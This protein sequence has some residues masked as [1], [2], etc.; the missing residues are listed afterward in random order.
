[1]ALAS[2]LGQVA[3]LVASALLAFVAV[4]HLGS[5]ER[6]G[7]FAI[8]ERRLARIF[9]VASAL[10]YVAAPAI[11]GRMGLSAGQWMVLAAGCV[12]LLVLALRPPALPTAILAVVLAGTAL[13]ASLIAATVIDPMRAD[14]MPVIA[15]ALSDVTSGHSPYRMHQMPAWEVPL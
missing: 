2:A 7:T 5:H 15:Q 8:S 1:T 14:M 4:S 6:G 9:L 11:V 12:G 13:R 3:A 10:T